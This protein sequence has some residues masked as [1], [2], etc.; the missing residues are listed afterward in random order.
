MKMIIYKYHTDGE[1][2]QFEVRYI[3]KIVDLHVEC[4]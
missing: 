4:Q 2:S 3:K 1:F